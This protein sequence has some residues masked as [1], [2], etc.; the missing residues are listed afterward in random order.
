[1]RNVWWLTVIQRFNQPKQNVQKH[2]K[3]ILI[4]YDTYIYIYI[5]MMLP[6]IMSHLPTIIMGY[7][8]YPIPI[9]CS[10]GPTPSEW[11]AS[12]K[13][14]SRKIRNKRKTRVTCGWDGG[15]LMALKF[16]S[17]WGCWYPICSMYGIFTYKTGWFLGQIFVNTLAPWSIWVWCI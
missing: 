8:T 11:Q 15:A 3:L 1:M 2:P 5:N 17:P 14:I 7:I 12:D 16:A 13:R 4:I 6:D 10:A 9:P